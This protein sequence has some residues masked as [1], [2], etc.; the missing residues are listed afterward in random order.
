[1]TEWWWL[2]SSVK[3]KGKWDDE[4]LY[5]EGQWKRKADR[6]GMSAGQSHGH[7][8]RQSWLESKN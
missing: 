3:E 4:R 6:T 1:M 8:T 7:S 2:S 5:E